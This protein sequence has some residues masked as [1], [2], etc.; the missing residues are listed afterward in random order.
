MKARRYNNIGLSEWTP[1]SPAGGGDA[2]STDASRREMTQKKAN[3]KQICRKTMRGSALLAK[4]GQVW[5]KAWQV[6]RT[7]DP[8]QNKNEKIYRGISRPRLHQCSENENESNECCYTV[9]MINMH[10]T[11][12]LLIFPL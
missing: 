6:K 7:M 8:Q 5:E 11:V 1:K 12:S 3:L 9:K 4:P 2:T 10:S